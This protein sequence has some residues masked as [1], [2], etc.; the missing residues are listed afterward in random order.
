MPLTTS[1]VEPRIQENASPGFTESAADEVASL[2]LQPRLSEGEVEE[3]T[4]AVNA[5]GD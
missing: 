4:D 2:P 3:I 1:R 5:F